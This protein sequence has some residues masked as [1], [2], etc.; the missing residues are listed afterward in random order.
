MTKTTSD[1]PQSECIPCEDGIDKNSKQTNLI[2]LAN[3]H[4]DWNLNESA[5]KLQRKYSFKNFAKTVF[6]VN[7]VA[8]IADQQFH[9]PDIQ[10]GYNYCTVE[11]STHAVDGLTTN[12]FI[13]AAMVDK[14][15]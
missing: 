5:D 15:L 6:F 12:D 10:F 13:C 9:H 4:E 2:L 7:A 8:H 3:L 11:Y 1:T 14:L